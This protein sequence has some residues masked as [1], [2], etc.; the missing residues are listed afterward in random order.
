MSSL[1]T[2]AGLFDHQNHK[3]NTEYEKYEP[4]NQDAPIPKITQNLEHWSLNRN[5]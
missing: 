1:I 2:P 5:R 4:N 3:D